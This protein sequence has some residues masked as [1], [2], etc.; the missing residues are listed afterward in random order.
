M[1]SAPTGTRTPVLA[2]RGLCPRPLDD[3]GKRLRAGEILPC[4]YRAVNRGDKILPM[5]RKSFSI[6]LILL[7]AAILIGWVVYQIPAVNN[8]LYWRVDIALT[9]LR[10]VINPVEA[11]PTPNPAET[12]EEQTASNTAAPSPTAITRPTETTSAALI[13][14][15]ISTNIPTATLVPTATPLPKMVELEAKGW[16]QQD[17]NNCGPA[18]L[19]G[20]LRFYGWEGNQFDISARIKPVRQDRNVNIEELAHFSRNYAGWLNTQY[21]VGGDLE[22][23]K[24]FVA[25]GI[26]VL[27][28][29]SFFFDGEYWPND[30]LW[31]AHYLLVTGYDE[32]AGTFTVQDTYRGPNRKLAFAT[33]DEYWQP[34]NRLY[35]LIYL[36]SQEETVKS[37]LGLAWDVDLNRQQ[38]LEAAEAEI[39]A[40]PEDAYAW[41]NKGTNLLYFERYEEAAQAYDQARN[42]G[43]PQR[44]LRYQ[45]GPF[46]AYFHSGRTEA[47]LTLTGYALQ[48]TPNSE[49][50]LLWHGWG[51]YRQGDINGAVTDFNAALEANRFYLDA[52]Y[53]LDYVLNQ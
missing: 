27:I 10:G 51:L 26:P 46:F 21:R 45:F 37:I 29:S 53:A 43:L 23:L 39:A 7:I 49:E 9:Y 48:R 44:M 25:A 19:S 22:L 15:E 52:Q 20:Y 28:E 13:S 16:E 1:A 32:T 11:I 50:A 4:G 8:R 18:A 40:N 47:L 30:D 2:L 14:T 35:M 12:R 6:I 42:I 24:E 31:A 17:W 33:V 38:A 34:F 41:F 3:G 5:S 36:P